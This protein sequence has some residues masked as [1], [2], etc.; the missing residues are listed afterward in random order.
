[1]ELQQLKKF[2]AWFDDYVAGFYGNDGFIDANLK[3]KEDHTRR[4]CEE[5]LYLAK[6]LGLSGNQKRIVEVIALFHD[7]GRFRQ[8]V[9]Y[10]TYNDPQSVNHCLLGLEVLKKTKVLEAVDAGERQL[11]EKAIEYHGLKELPRDLDGDCLLLAK[12][13]RDADKID[14]LY[15]MTDCYR[16]YAENTPGFK[17]ELEL[18]DQPGYSDEV[19]EALL[20]GRRI[21]Y[22]ELRT[23]N[24]MKLCLLGWVY[25]VNFVP[26]I[27]R[28]K[29]C[30]LLEMLVD[31][32][33]KTEDIKRVKEKIFK[34]VD[35]R[36]SQET[37][38][39]EK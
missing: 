9:K 32:L 33:P 25:D 34:Y 31:F 2:R 29:Q 1:M 4:T 8:F 27:K 35:F 39:K 7:I 16:Q 28:I 10:L 12:L 5:A 18:P 24:D 37:T 14:S 13:I 26:T 36:I 3:L 17:L 19:I 15:V 11:I 20:S 6:E 38:K 21:D 23:L 30:R 22:C